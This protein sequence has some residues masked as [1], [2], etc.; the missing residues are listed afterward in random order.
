MRTSHN[1]MSCRYSDVIEQ[2][3][4][5]DPPILLRTLLSLLYLDDNR[6]DIRANFEYLSKA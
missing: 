4:I 2:H 6:S 3:A 5:L 1:T